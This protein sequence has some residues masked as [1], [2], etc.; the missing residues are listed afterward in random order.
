M[1]Q[2]ADVASPNQLESGLLDIDGRVPRGKES[3]PNGNAWKCISVWTW[4]G[5]WGEWGNGGED[6][7][8]GGVE[9]M[10]VDDQEQG[11]R[12]GRKDRGLLFYLR[13][14]TMYGISG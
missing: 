10:E 12:G 4:R 14:G 1:R 5:G 6:G 13:G 3:R 11:K 9:G 7:G 8:V 2:I